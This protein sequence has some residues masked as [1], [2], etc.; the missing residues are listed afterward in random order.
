MPIS[1]YLRSLRRLVGDR[2]LLLPGVAAVIRD[3]TGAIL[4]MHRADDG[5]WGLP[6]GGMEPGETPAETIVREVFEETGLNVVPE[7]VLGVFGGRQFRHTY[8]N[9]DEVEYTT[10]VFGCRI[11][12]GSLAPQ[13]GEALDLRYFPPDAMPPLVAPYPEALFREADRPEARFDDGGSPGW[14]PT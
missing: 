1:D 7:R 4:L 11:V 5:C 3:E 12:G 2:L 13:D 10:V 8:P 6:A 14:T 9:G